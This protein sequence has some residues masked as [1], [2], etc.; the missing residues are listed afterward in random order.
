MKKKRR[1]PQ[2]RL[3]KIKHMREWAETARLCASGCERWTSGNFAHSL[4][5]HRAMLLHMAEWFDRAAA[6]R[7][8]RERRKSK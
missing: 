8:D 1:P 4:A 5:G 6:V 2:S 3:V 7:K